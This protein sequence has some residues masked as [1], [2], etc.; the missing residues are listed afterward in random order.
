MQPKAYFPCKY[1]TY[2]S[3]TTLRMRVIADQT[4]W[5]IKEKLRGDVDD[6]VS[7]LF[8]ALTPERLLKPMNSH[9]ISPTF[10]G[11]LSLTEVSRTPSTSFSPQKA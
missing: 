4:S 10:P 9:A 1:L 8:L 3:G 7:A 2:L 11:A 5:L 6:L